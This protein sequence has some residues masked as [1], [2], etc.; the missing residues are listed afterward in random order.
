MRHFILLMALLFAATAEARH[1]RFLG[2]HPIAAK[3]GGGYCYIEVPHMHM[4]PPDHAE[5]YQQVGEDYVFT[6]DPSPFGYEG[7]RFQFYG[8]HPV[9][10]AP[11]V[12]CYLDG[13]H[14]HPYRVPEG[15]EYKMTND[16]AFYVAPLPDAYARLRPQRERAVNEVYR[17]YGSLRPQVQVTPPPEWHGTPYVAPGVEVAAP[18]VN[19]EVR[20]PDVGVPAPPPAPGVYVEPPR[21]PGAVVV[22]PPQ[23]GGVYVE[24]PHPGGVYV[25]PMRPPGAV[26][27]APPHPGGVIIEGPRPPGAVIVA[28][29]R[30]GVVVG[31]PGVVVGA[32][33]VVVEGHGHV[34][35]PGCEH[36][37]G[38]HDNGVRRHGGH[39]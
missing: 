1:V 32:P 18:G 14:Y 16:V 37:R 19:V 8:H 30:P 36:D 20:G 3:N 35:F 34:H 5:L 7:E 13:P 2:P 4:Y 31:A 10:G 24:P 25:E 22:A 9:P 11:G 6:G 12:Y 23:P 26:V 33:G 39:K 17:P 28:P 38:H 21:P 29:P 15:P 27:V